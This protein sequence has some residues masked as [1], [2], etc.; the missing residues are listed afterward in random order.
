[1]NI[2]MAWRWLQT[3]WRS[4]EFKLLFTALLLSTSLIIGLSGF[5]DRVQLMLVGQSAEFLAADRVLASPRP[6]EQAWLV[7]AERLQL[8]QAQ[9]LSFQ[10][11]LYSGD[12]MVLSSV[13]AASA[14][15]PLK[16]VLK[17]REALYG[18]VLE[19]TQGPKPGELWADARLFHQLGI[20]LGDKVELGDLRLIASR[21][22]VSEPDRGAGSFS[23]G[24][25]VLMSLQD[26][27]Q[28]GLVQF[29]ARLKYRYLFAG[30]KSQLD[31]LFNFLSPQLTDS[32]SWI[33]LES[34]QPSIAI[35]LKRGKYF[36]YLAS[37]IIIVLSSVAIA[38]SSIRY[39]AG[40]I[41]HIAVLKSL[42][43]DT[44]Q[45]YQLM[46]FILISLFVLVFA[47]GSVIGSLVQIVLVQLM[48]NIMQLPVPKM[49]V[50]ESLTIYG[51]GALCCLVALLAFMLP[52][53]KRLASV[54]AKHVFMQAA[55]REM[56]LH[57]SSFLIGGLG[58]LVLIATYSQS[59]V[60]SLVLVLALLILV[61][62]LMLPAY[63]LMRR[64]S[65]LRLQAAST[66]QLAITQL[67]RR[68]R[69]NTFLIGVFALCLSLLF[70]LLGMQSSLYE[71][72]REQLPAKTPNYFLLNIK[73]DQWQGVDQYLQQESFVA[74]DL[75]PMVRGRLVEINGESVRTL[76]SKEKLKRAGA[77]RELNLSWSD[78]L[79]ADN[80]LVEGQWFSNAKA[81]DATALPEVSVES[82]IAERLGIGMGDTLMFQV[83]AERFEASVSSIREVEWDRMRPN[84]Y[85]MFEGQTLQP[86]PKTYMTSFF[87]ETSRQGEVG[88]LLKAFP[89]LVLF[90]VDH[91][92]K[93]IRSIVEQVSLGL[94]WVVIFVFFASMLVLISTVQSS[95]HERLQENALLRAIGASKSHLLGALALEFALLGGL[96]G[97]LAVVVGQLILLA[98]QHYLLDLTISLQMQ[99][100][101]LPPILGAAV[102]CVT[103]V[104]ASRHVVSSPPASLL[105]KY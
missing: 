12:D 40:H 16:G 66:P 76:V 59:W 57:R 73:P 54:P 38:M 100:W 84:F 51:L 24:P 36:F 63:Y 50:L 37:A 105:R 15:Y 22:L 61:G 67:S 8:Q 65:R 86:F 98:L 102:V 23:L 43:A 74:E 64:L 46:A 53:L 70:V 71:Q 9:T 31:H 19:T 18:E 99:L 17:Y 101:W 94:R 56:P 78:A 48:A 44:Q 14:L 82:Q 11:M 55:L 68:L 4:S 92:I 75:Y 83:A 30:D 13:K 62:L 2:K 93:Q 10:S 28:S 25:R 85:M 58:L 7:E 1:M 49:S 20:A 87:L 27:E 81:E 39:A 97:L 34:S 33:D 35:A 79:P 80:K 52:P 90:D 72:W 29:G 103:G 104:L 41:Q 69:L 88:A 5:M 3:D 21:E 45:I 60:L 6:V 32:H 42:G 77:D 47:L 26:M 91:L 95:M 96:G 89:S